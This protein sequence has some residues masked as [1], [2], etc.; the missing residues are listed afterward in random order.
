[1]SDTW[2]IYVA[3]T[4]SP[5]VAEIQVKK[6]VAYHLVTTHYL[7]ILNKNGG[8]CRDCGCVRGL[9]MSQN[10]YTGSPETDRLVLWSAS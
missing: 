10:R 2:C 1:M 8:M 6:Y 4:I 5:L 3:S 9:N 7:P